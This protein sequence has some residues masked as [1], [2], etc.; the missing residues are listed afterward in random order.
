MRPDA[1]HV[2]ATVFRSLL[3]VWQSGPPEA[4]LA[5]VTDDYV[6]H[7]LHLADGNRTPLEYP[8][9]IERFRAAN[10]GT[11][12]EVEAQLE[13]GNHVCTRVTA[14]RDDPEGTLV[15]RGINIS[16]CEGDR[17]AEE[18]AIWTDWQTT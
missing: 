7:M 16:R 17:V 2:P 18:W 14:L 9:W 8:A 13:S 5:V 12:F 15:A 10:P 6:G 4:V 3:D 11:Q 1:A